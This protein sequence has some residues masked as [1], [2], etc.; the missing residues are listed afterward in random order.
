MSSDRLKEVYN[1]PRWRGP[2]RTNV[3]RR[4]GGQCQA[5][6]HNLFGE[7]VRCPVMD[8]KYGGKE[9]LTVNHKDPYGPDPYDEGELEALCRHH[10]GIVDGG[11][12][13][14]GAW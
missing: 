14:R 12:A 1:S 10:H 3:L 8:K 5:V 7:D 11:R 6:V 13:T 2:T 9:S 4:A